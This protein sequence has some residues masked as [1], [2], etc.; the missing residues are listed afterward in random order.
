MLER[1]QKDQLRLDTTRVPV[2]EE[3]GIPGA[4]M[5]VLSS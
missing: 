1:G 4:G 5:S 3:K 2:T